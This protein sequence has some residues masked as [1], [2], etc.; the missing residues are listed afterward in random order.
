MTGWDV[1]AVSKPGSES[2]EHFAAVGPDK[3]A[4]DAAGPRSLKDAAA[5]YAKNPEWSIV[6]AYKFISTGDV[7]EADITKACHD[8]L[9]IFGDSLREHVKQ[10]PQE[11]EEDPEEDHDEQADDASS[12]ASFSDMD[13]WL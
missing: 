1:Y 13:L 7:E 11:A 10:M 5:V 8:A 2:Y 3:L 6:N 9:A 12:S 4:W